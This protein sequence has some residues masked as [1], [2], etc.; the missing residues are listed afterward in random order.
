[1][2]N[3]HQ[4]VRRSSRHFRATSHLTCDFFFD[5]FLFDGEKTIRLIQ[6]F[7]NSSPAPWRICQ[8]ECWPCHQTSVSQS[9][10]TGSS[11]VGGK[12]TDQGVKCLWT[13]CA[14]TQAYF[15]SCHGSL[16][17]VSLRRWTKHAT[18]VRLMFHL[19]K[20]L[21]L[22]LSKRNTKSFGGKVFVKLELSSSPILLRA[23]E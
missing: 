10:F 11:F 9:K 7:V 1:M 8:R 3:R 16:R 19:E 6:L 23:S 13:S 12:F 21:F 2:I 17:W 18:F 15:A 4:Q 5:F 20:A 22:F 14:Q